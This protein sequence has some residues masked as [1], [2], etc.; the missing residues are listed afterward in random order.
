ML[1]VSQHFMFRSDE[2]LLSYSAPYGRKQ[3]SCYEAAC[4]RWLGEHEDERQ[5]MKRYT[6]S[7]KK[8]MKF[9]TRLFCVCRKHDQIFSLLVLEY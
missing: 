5:R 1:F 6:S 7:N 9:V 3:K 8:I 4:V 2:K